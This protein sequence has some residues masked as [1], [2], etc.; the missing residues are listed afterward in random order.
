MFIWPR[1]GDAC[2]VARG[3]FRTYILL[4]MPIEVQT[5][6]LAGISFRIGEWV[7]EPSL[8]RL[9]QGEATTQLELKVMDVLVCLAERAGEVVTRQEIVDRVWATEFISDNTLTH[10]ITEIRNALGDDARNPSFIETIHRRGYRLI[11]P[12]ESSVPDEPGEYKVA[13][14]PVRERVASPEVERSPYPG[15]ASFTEADAEFFFGREA[16]VV[17]MWRKLTSRRLLAVI[18]PS[19][20]GKSSFLRA[21]VI[22]AR[23]EGWGVLVCQPEEAPFAALA[24]ALVPEFAGDID[25]T[26]QLVDIRDGDRAIA[27]VSRWRG[28][29]TQAML[30]VDQFEELYTQN[31]P[32]TQAGFAGFLRKLVDNCDIHVLVAMRDDFLFRVHDYPE[33]TPILDEL[34]LLGAPAAESLHLA[35][36]EPARR[37]GFAFENE[38][39][40]DEMIAEV[41][42]ERGALPM[43]AFAVARLWDRRDRERRLLTDRA[44]EEIGGVGGAL[45]R[46]A[47]TTLKAIGDERLPIVREI[48][49]NLVTAAG[50]R[51]VSEAGELLTVFP[52]SKRTDAEQVLWRLIDS[53]L[54]TSFE[55]QNVEGESRRRV[56]IVHEALLLSWPRLVRWQTQDADAAQLRDQLRQ[57][58]RTWDEHDRTKDYLWT[59]KAYREFALWHESYPGGLSDLEEAYAAAMTDH[60]KRRKRWRRATVAASFAVLVTVLVVIVSLWRTSVH[61]TRRAEAQGL[62]AMARQDFQVYGRSSRALAYAVA[63]RGE[64]TSLD[65]G[66]GLGVECLRLVGGGRL[67]VRHPQRPGTYPGLGAWDLDS[68]RH[69]YLFSGEELGWCW[70]RDA[71]LAVSADGRYAAATVV[72]PGQ[73]GRL[74][75]IVANLGDASSRQLESFSGLM[76]D[77]DAA[78][79]TIVSWDLPARRGPFLQVGQISSKS[80]HLVPNPFDVSLIGFPSLSPRADLIA[81]GYGDGSIWL[82]PVPNLDNPPLHTLPHNELIDKLK[83]LTNL[84][85]VRDEESST[86]W[87]IE[88]GPFPGWETVPEW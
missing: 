68:G 28:R 84:R 50:T 9:S 33:L 4:N 52:E 15:L 10:A 18:G 31:P 73:A 32:E 25:A 76:W 86:G 3:A 35:L 49:R 51:A 29:H 71:E 40:P 42:G 7:V 43:L 55:E 48:F 58:A 24:R 85:V 88:V 65:V 70:D 19:G 64:L 22:P 8:N 62:L 41:E 79:S 83:T 87:K 72:S 80:P 11:A 57:A 1:D 37:L 44:Y 17:Q 75:L 77:L 26:A 47:E 69:S 59:G 34:T 46:H 39:L 82:Y 16:E 74:S 14:F 38:G 54:L 23:P 53:R 13:R 60:A 36:V 20:V 67:L 63:S 61:Q 56:E 6:D 45:G 30:I 12:I 21:G 81:Q 5:R 66:D 2:A 27:M 78:G